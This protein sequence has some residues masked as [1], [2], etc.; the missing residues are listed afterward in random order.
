MSPRRSPQDHAAPV[1]RLEART[2]AL[3]AVGERGVAPY[4]TAGDGG[5]DTTLAAL[6]AL[7]QGGAACIELGVPFSDPIADGPVLQAAADRALAAGTTL[8]AILEMVARFREEG[9]A[10]PIALMSYANPLLRRGWG[11]TCAGA[12]EAGVDALIVPDLALEEGAPL[13]EAAA[14]AGLCPVFFAAP[15]SPEARIRAAAEASR[16]FLYV[17]GR[18]GVT[19]GGTSFGD[20]TQ[21]FLARVAALSPVPTAVGFGIRSAADVRA[22]VRHADLAIVGTAM[23][24]RLHQ[25][26]AA[27]PE[28]AAGYLAELMEGLS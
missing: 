28:A 13:R 23:V 22:A 14:A 12:A 21:D 7:D 11:G 1:N 4:L 17:V 18:V 15:T 6:H 16:G 10:V 8:A 3:R 25:A 27:A 24:R 2:A 5:L 9:G 20:D 26:G 19:G